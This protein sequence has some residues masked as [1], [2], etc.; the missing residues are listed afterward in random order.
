MSD[1]GRMINVFTTKITLKVNP[2]SFKNCK[3]QVSGKHYPQ[4]EKTIITRSQEETVLQICN[5]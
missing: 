5:L 2:K 1:T 3:I 4:L